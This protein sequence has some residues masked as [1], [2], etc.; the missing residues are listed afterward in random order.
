MQYEHG[1]GSGIQNS[2][3][4]ANVQHD[5]FDETSER[6]SVTNSPYPPGWETYPLQLMRAPIAPDS[7]KLKPHNLAAMA[8]GRNFAEKETTHNKIVYPHV[9]PLFKRP[10]FVLRPERMKYWKRQV[11]RITRSY[12]PHINEDRME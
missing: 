3:L 5:E 6:E 10:K 4:E 8:Q 12:M 7:R 9:M 11:G 1:E 2:S